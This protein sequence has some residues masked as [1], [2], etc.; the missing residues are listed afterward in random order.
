MRTALQL[1]ERGTLADWLIRWGI[2]RL[3][4]RRLREED[5]GSPEANRRAKEE[6]VQSMWQS[7]IAPVPEKANEQHYEVPPE[8]FRIVLGKRMKYSAC[9]WPDG[10]DTLDDAEEAMLDLTCRTAEIEDGMMVLD[11]GCGWGSTAL[12]IAEKY[13]RCSVI[14]VSNS[15]LQRDYIRRMCK[16]SGIANVLTVT[17][18][19]NDFVPHQRVDR[20]VSVEMFE[21]MRNWGRLLERAASWLRPGG[22]AFIHVFAHR[23]FPYLFKVHGNEDWMAT[24]FFAEGLMPSDDLMLYFQDHLAVEENRRIDGTHYRKTADAWLANLDRNRAGALS[25][26]ASAY[27]PDQAERWVQRW[28]IFFMAVSE[29]WGLDNGREWIVSHYRLSPKNAR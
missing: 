15:R 28:R 23:R 18:D 2:R 14:A 5:R 21:H 13:P 8:F 26:F 19:M 7:P 20:I 3:D 29:M 25:L 12:W 17:A 22:K 6:F 1:A 24:H 11:L 10:V 27:G 16:A 9:L 4:R